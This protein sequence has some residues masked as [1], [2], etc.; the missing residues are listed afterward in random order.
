[1]AGIADKLKSLFG[2]QSMVRQFFVWTVVAE[3]VSTALGPFYQVVR[4]QANTV[5]PNAPLTPDAL[6]NLVVR[7]EVGQDW[8]ASEAR[9]AGIHPNLFEL[10]VKN[11]G[12]PPALQD[13]LSLMRRGKVSRDAVIRAIKQSHV[14]N[15]WIDT[16]LLLGVQP[17]T[18]T[19][20]L[21]AYLQGQV[22]GD[23]ARQLFAQLGGDP[24]FFDLLYNTEG[25]APTPNEAADMA[26]KG[27]IPWEGS[28]AGVVSFE[29]AFLEG[30]W[31]NKWLA[32]WRRMSEYLPPPRTI[33]A[34]LREGSLTVEEATSLL[35]RH[36]VPLDL[37][38]AYLN[39]ASNERTLKAKELTESTVSALY[40]EHAINESQAREF[41]LKLRYEPK[42]AD[43]VLT[44]W[45]L[46]RELKFRNTAI[47]TVHTQ[48][49]NHRISEQQ[50]VVRLDRLGV[51]A[52]QRDS[53][54][55]LWKLEEDIKVTL[56]TPAQI[57][58]A[59]RKEFLPP[60]DALARLIQLGYS[61]EDAVIYLSI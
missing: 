3:V 23:R 41:L 31:R 7:G 37:I 26:H 36:G 6:A 12:I 17:P 24:E 55:R 27:I 39:N 33:T 1:V 53:L 29:Q 43:F 18:P 9:K 40:Q 11:A 51:P 4:D 50:T 35:H 14:K 16:I 49:I 52:T 15:E 56:L 28:G 32:P 45:K 5:S 34:M 20:I 58:S 48:F 60:E 54:M 30:P 59:M 2:A 38:P 46:A 44:S 57:K 13:M 22:D 19:E 61:E 21:R 47:S 42:E 25:S 10:L 8:A